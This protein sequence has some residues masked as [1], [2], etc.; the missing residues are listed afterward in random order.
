MDIYKIN[1][2]DFLVKAFLSLE[3][4]DECKA[5]LE[6]LLTTKEIID[7]SQ[8]IMVAKMLSQ[9]EVYSQIAEKTGASS[10]TISRVNRCYLYGSDGYKKVLDTLAKEDP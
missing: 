8:R 6:D 1:G 9:Q 7:L 2:A 3:S 4:E 5:F 10:A